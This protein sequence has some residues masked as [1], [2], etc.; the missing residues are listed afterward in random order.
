M[1]IVWFEGLKEQTLKFPGEAEVLP[2]DYS[3]N[4]C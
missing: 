2:V 3:A 1:L 4:T